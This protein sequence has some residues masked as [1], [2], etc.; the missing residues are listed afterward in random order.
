V[1]LSAAD[2]KL[3]ET[4]AK[5]VKP[6]AIPGGIIGEVGA[7]LRTSKGDVFTG[8]CLHLVC[9]LGCCGE[10]TAIGTAVTALGAFTIDTIVAV[11]QTGIIPPCGRCRELMNVLSKDGPNTWVIVEM[12]KKVPLKELLPIAWDSSHALSPHQKD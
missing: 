5:L 11:N 8:I 3:V 1:E 9:G 7:A 6:T 4:A 12:D 2:L 10:H